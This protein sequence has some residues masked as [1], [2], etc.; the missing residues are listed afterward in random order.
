M[1]IL[2]ELHRNRNS[3]RLVHKAPP[4][5]G[6]YY[7]LRVANEYTG[8]SGTT[9]SVFD[10]SN[11]RTKWPMPSLSGRI[12]ARPGE[13]RTGGSGVIGRNTREASEQFKSTPLNKKSQSPT[14]EVDSAYLR[15][16]SFG[17]LKNPKHAACP[18]QMRFSM[19]GLQGRSKFKKVNVDVA[20]P[21][22]NGR[23][24]AANYITGRP[25]TAQRSH[26]M[27]PKQESGSRQY[28]KQP[29]FTSKMAVPGN[30]FSAGEMPKLGKTQN[31]NL[32]KQSKEKSGNWVFKKPKKESLARPTPKS[33]S[34]GRAPNDLT[35]DHFLNE[36]FFDLYK[37]DQK[38]LSDLDFRN[39]IREMYMDKAKK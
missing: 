39:K 8:V 34:N 27:A 35:C 23:L 36:T 9:N 11:S 3:L 1:N 7:S 22:A 19:E 33:I 14:E 20:D 15:K 29:R 31:R 37:L 12:D 17:M 28:F 38:G 18:G 5:I 24:N 10:S 16:R 4:P 26:S 2:T 30:T 6:Q 13:K 21:K 32:Q 25:G